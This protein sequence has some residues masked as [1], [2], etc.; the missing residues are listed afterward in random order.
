MKIA[1]KPKKKKHPIEKL[2]SEDIIRITNYLALSIAILTLWAMEG[3]DKSKLEE[4]IDG[5]C[6]LIEENSSKRISV[7]DLITYVKTQ[8]NVDVIARIDNAMK[9]GNRNE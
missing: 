3:W 9:K 2:K 6:A 4:F 5:Y 1:K 7:W 8:T